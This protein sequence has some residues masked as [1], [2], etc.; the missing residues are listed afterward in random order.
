MF[1]FIHNLTLLKTTLGKKNMDHVSSVFGHNTTVILVAQVFCCRFFF[2]IAEKCYLN[3]SWVYKYTQTDR[4]GFVK[5]SRMHLRTRF[6]RYEWVTPLGHPVYRNVPRAVE[7]VGRVAIVK[8]R[9]VHVVRMF[10][11]SPEFSFFLFFF[12]IH[13]TRKLKRYPRNW[14]EKTNETDRLRLVFH[15]YECS[16]IPILIISRDNIA[17]C[18]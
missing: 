8:Q 15:L 18:A 5:V 16:V 10:I 7:S 13:R 9:A 14:I 17:Y 1:D 6:V 12:L 11:F 4:F 3:V 2:I